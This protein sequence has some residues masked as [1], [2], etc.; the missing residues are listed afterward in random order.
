[1]SALEKQVDGNHYKDLAIQPV[2]FA[3]ANELNFCQASILKYVTRWKS[4]NGVAD[5]K[6]AAHFAQLWGELW[7]PLP[8][9]MDNEITWREYSFGN[10][11][12]G[13]QAEIVYQLCSPDSARVA[14]RVA[15]LIRNYIA[16]VSGE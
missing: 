15:C 5:L 12:D 6:K 10:E 8:P 1:M 4:K 11:L 13:W 9:V 16:E 7:S 2:Q 3:M 14:G